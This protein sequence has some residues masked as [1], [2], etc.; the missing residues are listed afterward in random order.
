M[1]N[2]WKKIPLSKVLEV[3]SIPALNPD[4]SKRI[5]VRLN[6]KGVESRPISAIEDE[7][8]TTY[9]LRKSGQF[10]YGKQNLHKGAFGLI[11]DALHLYESSQDLPAFDINTDVM[12]GEWLVYFLRRAN[13]Y[14]NLLEKA[15]G[16]G[17]KRIHED[18]FL[19]LEILLP[20]KSVQEKIINKI[21]LLENKISELKEANAIKIKAAKNL[22]FSVYDKYIDSCDWDNLENVAPIIRRSIKTDSSK[23]YLEIGL[24]SFGKGTFHKPTIKGTDVGS[25]RL[26]AILSD[27]LLFSNIFS[28]EGAIAV[29][30]K[31][32]SGCVGSHRYITCL[33]D[34]QRANPYFLCYHFLTQKGLDDISKASPGSAGRNKTL[35]LAKLMQIKVPL[36]DKILQDKHHLIQTKVWDLENEI[37]ILEQAFDD[38]V[39]SYLDKAFKGEL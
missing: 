19:A 5:T 3:S 8:A 28:W 33:V 31:E 21:R 32:D 6:C 29:A 27:D 17:S 18:I 2:N 15:K 11:P 22:V 1:S 9:Y 10:I 7:G 24:R 34:Q 36:P 35:G 38:L 23:E 25:K 13:Y 30:K 4:Q 12:Y 14:T 37:K 16:T 39:P 20:D 26:F